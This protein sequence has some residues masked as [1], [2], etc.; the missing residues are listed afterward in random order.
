MSTAADF[1]VAPQEELAPWAEEMLAEQEETQAQETEE[2]A[3]KDPAANDVLVFELP[4]L[5]AGDAQGLVDLIIKHPD[6]YEQILATAAGMLGND[7]L[8]KA[9][10]I[11]HGAPPQAAEEPKTEETTPTEVIEQQAA[12]ETSAG[13]AEATV[14]EVQAAKEEQ[15]A[16]TE[17]A[18]PEPEP[19]WVV[20]ARAYNAAHPDEVALFNHATGFSCTGAGGEP[21]P[22]AVA[23]WQAANGVAPDGRVGKE[24]ADAAWALMPVEQPA[25]PAQLPEE[26][27]VA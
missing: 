13:T 1:T 4:S 10:D 6:L 3:Q 7:T 24:T 23:N 18:E 17:S 11:V 22:N 9:L 5:A 16:P 12:E 21:D 14:E 8:A 26:T 15:T 25:S 2:P 19:G 27:A 20:R